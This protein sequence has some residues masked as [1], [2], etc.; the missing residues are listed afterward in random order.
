MIIQDAPTVYTIVYSCCTI[1]KLLATVL[2]LGPFFYSFQQLIVLGTAKIRPA[3][4]SVMVANYL[5]SEKIF[6]L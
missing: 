2:V 1:F 5:I 3:F 4:V 6:I